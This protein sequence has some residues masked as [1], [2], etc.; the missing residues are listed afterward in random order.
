MED[1][2]GVNDQAGRMT[3]VGVANLR[4]A[5]RRR[6]VWVGA[7][8]LTALV[9]A[10]TVVAVAGANRSGPA[11][12]S[13]GPATSTEARADDTA[14]SVPADSAAGSPASGTGAAVDTAMAQTGTG[15]VVP[16]GGPR[17]VRNASVQVEV[18]AGGFGS[19]FD[20]AQALATANGGFVASSS[21]STARATG[22][23]PATGVTRE[24][25]DGRDGPRAGELSLRVPADRFDALRRSLAELGN[26][27]GESV[28][29]E[30]VT[31]QLVDYEARLKSLAAEED[32]LRTL[33]G[34]ATAVGE[35][36]AVQGRLFEVRQQVEQLQAQ[37][38]QLDRAAT[39]AT[40]RVSIFEPGAVTASPAEPATGLAGSIRDAVRGSIAVV[41]GMIV[42]VGWLAPVAL[43]GL[44]G[45]GVVRLRRRTPA[46]ATPEPAS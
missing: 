19:A 25:D 16:P 43:L 26:V 31:A 8:A 1:Q 15:G 9:G 6:T 5:L 45:W 37:R 22:G 17:V 7:V 4:R 20:R 2:V 29:G 30:D 35:V 14:G 24:G 41:G 21:T 40:V 13:S 33:V 46:V 12:T 36:L 23:V 10:G 34:R 32:A 28:Q 11:S 18:G 38:D 27:E 3:R 39:F 44:A 42:V